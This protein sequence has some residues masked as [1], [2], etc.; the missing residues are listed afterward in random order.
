MITYDVVKKKESLNYFVIWIIV[1]YFTDNV[2][3]DIYLPIMHTLVN[4][5]N[6][7]VQ[8]IQLTYTASFLG[9]TLPQLFLGPLADRFGRRPLLLWGGVLFVSATILSMTATNIFQLI[10]GRFLQGIGIC[11]TN[12][13]RFTSVQELF[14]YKERVK[15]FAYI[16]FFGILSPLIGPLIGS[17][18]LTQAGWRYI[19]LFVATMALTSIYFFFLFIPYTKFKL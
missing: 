6:V 12:V 17:Y 2:A 9:T 13:I 16:G 4:V 3:N 14:D 15:I 18:I 1:L 8:V 5:F 7:S 19:F 10:I 11:C